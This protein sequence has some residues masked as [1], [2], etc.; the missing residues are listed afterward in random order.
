MACATLKED[1][2]PIQCDQL[3]QSF[4]M[5]KIHEYLSNFDTCNASI[6]YLRKSKDGDCKTELRYKEINEDC[7]IFFAV[8]GDYVY[9]YNDLI[10]RI[11]LWSKHPRMFGKEGL[12]GTHVSIGPLDG[13]DNAFD[14][15]I[16][17]YTDYKAR[18][19]DFRIISPNSTR[20]YFK[21]F[22]PDY[23][24]IPTKH[25]QAI[26]SHPE[27]LAYLWNLL[28]CQKTNNKSGG[29]NKKLLRSTRK[30][31]KNNSQIQ[32]IEAIAEKRIK[33]LLENSY[34]GFVRLPYCPK[35]KLT[36]LSNHLR[37]L[38][39]D[40]VDLMIMSCHEEKS[41][42]IWVQL[43]KPSEAIAKAKQ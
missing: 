38:L 37:K 25:N 7:H 32:D 23:N 11:V 36:K 24:L 13:D 16:T 5:S 18:V 41:S 39:T 19:G 33:P 26:P 21:A 3:H 20:E 27:F 22:G 31:I 2:K 42:F 9:F 1:C 29:G 43:S 4:S 15:H 14:I 40:N 8:K 12:N 10:H 28:R 35:N 30:K 34:A 6:I 17:N